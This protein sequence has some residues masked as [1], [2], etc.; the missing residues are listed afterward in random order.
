MMTRKVCAL[1]EITIAQVSPV[2]TPISATHHF[3]DFVL[4]N[5]SQGG[6]CIYNTSVIGLGFSQKSFG[7]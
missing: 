2:L 7:L 1:A 5:Q 3:K 4:L 6:M